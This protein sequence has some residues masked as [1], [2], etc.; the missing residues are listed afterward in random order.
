ML[1]CWSVVFSELSPFWLVVA[2]IFN[3][4]LFVPALIKSVLLFDVISLYV[5]SVSFAS[6]TSDF[7]LNFTLNICVFSF[8][9]ALKFT[10]KN[11]PFKL[12]LS[13]LYVVDQLFKLCT[14]FAFTSS[15]I[16][17][18]YSI[19][20]STVLIPFSPMFISDTL[21]VTVTSC[22]AFNSVVLDVKTAL[23]EF[24]LV[25]CT[26][27]PNNTIVNN[28]TIVKITFLFMCFSL[29][30]LVSIFLVF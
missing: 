13:S 7:T 24:V 14:E 28:K 5:I 10:A 16:V 9:P 21:S 26:C 2:F 8:T 11:F 25:A 4:T 30:F 22:P 27:T 23:N 18:S 19:I 29:L 1:C 12:L 20:P 6:V 15:N 17:L 3:F